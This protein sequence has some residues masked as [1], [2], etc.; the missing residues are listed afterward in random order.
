[1]KSCVIVLTI[2]FASGTFACAQSGRVLTVDR[3]GGAQYTSLRA[4][5]KAAQ[6]GDTIKI[7]PGSGP[8]REILM[9]TASGLPD[10]P[11][12]VDGSGETVTGFDPLTGFEKVGDVYVCDLKPWFRRLPA[13]QG[14]VKKDDSWVSNNP[15]VTLPVLPTVLAYNGER[16]VQ[17]AQTGQLTKYAAYSPEAGTLT[18]LPGVTP[19][20]W[21]IAMRQPVVQISNVSCHTYRNLKASGSL[22]DG[23]N[24]HGAGHDLIFE[25]IEGFNNLD[26]GFSSHDQ[27]VSEIRGGTFRANDNGI[28]NGGGGCSTKGSDIESFSNL[29]WGLKFSEGGVTE[30]KN[31]K[32]WNNGVTQLLLSPGAELIG[33]DVKVYR[34]PWT[35]KPW[36]NY[37]ESAGRSVCEPYMNETK[38]PVAEGLVEVLPEEQAPQGRFLLARSGETNK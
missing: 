35:S 33:E 18:L 3:R 16:V 26:E 15:K 20:G 10:Q 25:D 8:Y 21:E 1:M 32:A 14:F 22:N 28:A 19:E 29:G 12:T 37:Q 6:P 13:V 34:T 27:I 30:L 38:V 36:L 17:D 2:I 9:I 4:A 11:I 7:A 5:G 24:L 23:F 31:V